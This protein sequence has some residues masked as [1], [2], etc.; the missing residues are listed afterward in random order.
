MNDQEWTFTSDMD[1]VRAGIRNLVD[2][3][4]QKGFEIQRTV[5]HSSVTLMI[6][7]DGKH[8]AEIGVEVIENESDIVDWE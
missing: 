1:S 6:Y 7:K 3:L 8:L 5:Y 4:A 2:D